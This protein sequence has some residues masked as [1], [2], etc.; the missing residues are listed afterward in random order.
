MD[1]YKGLPLDEVLR[2]ARIGLKKEQR[3]AA[4]QEARLQKAQA[5]AAARREKIDAASKALEG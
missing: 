3:Q 1:E 4:A 5:K 2:F